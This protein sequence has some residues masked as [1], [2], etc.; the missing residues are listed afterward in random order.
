LSKSPKSPLL[1][2]LIYFPQVIPL[3]KHQNGKS[4]LI[5]SLSRKKRSLG[6]GNCCWFFI[7]YQKSKDHKT[8]D[9]ITVRHPES[10]RAHQRQKNKLKKNAIS[11]QRQSKCTRSHLI[12]TT[13]W[14]DKIWNSFCKHVVIPRKSHLVIIFWFL[15]G[16]SDNFEWLRI[17]TFKDDY[18]LFAH[19]WKQKKWK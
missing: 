10:H 5:F 3:A 15:F 12:K 6:S 18:F 17:H 14:D 4:F 8:L 2:D 11:N 9:W 19:T 16:L 13:T 1:H 7:W